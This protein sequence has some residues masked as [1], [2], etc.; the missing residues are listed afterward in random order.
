MT[1]IWLRLQ[2]FYKLI[3]RDMPTQRS[4]KLWPCKKILSL[5]GHKQIKKISENISWNTIFRELNRHCFKITGS[6]WTVNRMVLRYW[7][8]G[9]TMVNK[10]KCQGFIKEK[11]T[12]IYLLFLQKE[13]AKSFLTNVK[14]VKEIPKNWFS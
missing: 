3:I 8:S 14:F 2:Y 6:T 10:F 1:R 12:F 11:T 9:Y 4:C 7:Y 5:E 13:W